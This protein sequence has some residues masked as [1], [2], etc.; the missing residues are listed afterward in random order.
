MATEKFNSHLNCCKVSQLNTRIYRY[1]VETLHYKYRFIRKSDADNLARNRSVYLSDAFRL[2]F[3]VFGAYSIK[4]YSLP[5]CHIRDLQ[6]LFNQ[7]N[8]IETFRSFT[9]HENAIYN[10]LDCLIRLLTV[11]PAN[12]ST[13]VTLRDVTHLFRTL[14]SVPMAVVASSSFLVVPRKIL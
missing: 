4:F 11:L 14:Y 8:Q 2:A 1:E 3:E 6:L 7:L 13:A 10:A 9:K 5:N 12:R